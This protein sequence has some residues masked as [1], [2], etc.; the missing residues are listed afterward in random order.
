MRA[1]L[2]WFAQAPL[3]AEIACRKPIPFYVLWERHFTPI[4]ICSPTSQALT[5]RLERKKMNSYDH[6]SVQMVIKRSASLKPTFMKLYLAPKFKHI[7]MHRS[8]LNKIYKH[9]VIQLCIMFSSSSLGNLSPSF[10][11][12]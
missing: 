5:L 4:D 3:K 10:L 9:K 2:Q 6:Q 12:M 11:S 7:H 1:V 8:L